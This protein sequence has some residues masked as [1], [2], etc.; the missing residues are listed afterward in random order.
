MSFCAFAET[1]C[2]K[3]YRS[4]RDGCLDEEIY[5]TLTEE[6]CRQTRCFSSWEANKVARYNSCVFST[7]PSSKEV[8]KYSCYIS[9]E[10]PNG[11]LK[12]AGSGVFYNNNFYTSVNACPNGEI[13]TTCIC[14]GYLREDGEGYCNSYIDEFYSTESQ[15][16]D[17]SIYESVA[18]CCYVAEG[19]DHLGCCASRQGDQVSYLATTK[20][21]C[22]GPYQE[23][24]KG[25]QVDENGNE[26]VFDICDRTIAGEGYCYCGGIAFKEVKGGLCNG[27]DWVGN[28]YVAISSCPDGQIEDRS[29]YCDG[30]KYYGENHP[31]KEQIA[32]DACFKD[33]YVVF[34]ESPEA[35]PEFSTIAAIITLA[36]GIITMIFLYKKK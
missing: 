2:C 22:M 18:G 36:C 29:C 31:D 21:D 32:N 8:L 28:Q 13:K 23:W 17:Y 3:S 26:C 10:H 25:I 20:N 9:G 14:D 34:S 4:N 12:N 16:E 27:T 35:V 5:S 19:R 33:K 11:V 24:G 30:E 15:Y 1:G 7:C 6:S